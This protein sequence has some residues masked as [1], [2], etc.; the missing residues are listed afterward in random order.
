[1]SIDKNEFKCLI[2]E[3]SIGTRNLE[4]YPV[5]KSEVVVDDFEEG[6]Y[7]SD[8]YEVVYNANRRLC[9]SLNVDEDEDVEC[10]VSNLLCI[11][12]HLNMK[13]YDYGEYYGNK[14]VNSEIEDIICFYEES[15]EEEK[16]KYMKLISTIKKF[17]I[18]SDSEE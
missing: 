18:S 3:L 17:L 6:S 11:A 2:Y 9:D 5:E 1:M 16:T 15:S 12:K 10:I 4:E 13:M 8:T 14:A 7:C